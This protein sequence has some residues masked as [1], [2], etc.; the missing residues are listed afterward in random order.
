MTEEYTREEIKTCRAIILKLLES[1][2]RNRNDDKLLTYNV[3]RHFTK[4]YIPFADFKKIPAFAT[5]QKIRQHIQNKEG[6]F[7][8]TDPKVVEK[9]RYRQK[10]FRQEM[11]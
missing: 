3:M 11:A 2:E 10:V 5:I 4:I 1:D 7:P 6:L 8:P 9:R